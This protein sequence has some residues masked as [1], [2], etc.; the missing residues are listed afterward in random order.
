MSPTLKAF[1]IVESTGRPVRLALDDLAGA[2]GGLDALA[3]GLREAVGLD[4][5]LLRELA[6]AQH[7]DRDVAARG[8][9]GSPQRGGI[10]RGAVVEPRIEVREVHRL[11]VRP[12]HLERHRHLL[13]GP[14]QLAHAHVDRVLAALEARAVLGAGAGA[15][16]LLAAAGGLAGARALTA[17]DALARAARARSRGQRVQADVLGGD[18]LV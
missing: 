12:E 15:V 5:E 8:Q 7:L 4:G 11:R 3:R 2:A 13:V 14:A 18:D 1:R 6:V 17:A 9:A 16:A 10:D